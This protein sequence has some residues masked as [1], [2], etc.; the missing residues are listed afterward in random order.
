M[1]RSAEDE[2][3]ESLGQ[4][5]V[6][7]VLELMM[8][9]LVLTED[10]L[11]IL[12]RWVLD[13][14]SQASIA[15]ERGITQQAIAKTMSN[16]KE[17]ARN[18]IESSTEPNELLASIAYRAATTIP[19]SS[20]KDAGSAKHKVR[21]PSE[22]LMNVSIDGQW[23]RNKYK[24]RNHCVLPEYLQSCFGDNE[25]KCGLCHDEFGGSTCSRKAV[26]Q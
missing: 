23:V 8:E 21:W 16:I 6:S 19:K 13:S 12:S 20:R 7:D 22:F 10:E 4:Q 26:N 2:F 24:L 25:T 14:E 1:A 18:F 3:F 9:N 15:K 17:K 11:S 5:S